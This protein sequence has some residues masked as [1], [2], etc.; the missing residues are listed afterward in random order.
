[1]TIDRPISEHEGALFDAV[2]VLATIVMDLG[3]D[4]KIL[5]ERLTAARDT[6]DSL[7][8]THGAATLEFLIDALFPAPDPAPKPSFRIV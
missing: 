7:G 3:A 1:M 8:N 2:R 5:R 4:A 6:A